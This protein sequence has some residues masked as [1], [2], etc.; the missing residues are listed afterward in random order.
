MHL[1]FDTPQIARIV[2]D[3]PTHRNAL[4]LAMWRMLI[5]CCTE[6]RAKD[7]VRVVILTG[8]D[9]A[10]SSGADITEFLRIR[11]E[12]GGTRDYD[13]AIESAMQAVRTLDVPVVADIRGVCV[14]GGVA[15]ALMCDMRIMADDAR[16]GIPAG[17]LGIAYAP[18]WIRRLTEVVGP[19]A[20]SELLFT[21]HIFSAA[22]AMQW[23]FANALA[24]LSEIS[25]RVGELAQR[26]AGLA[27]MSI[28]ASKAAI[29]E[30]SG[31]DVN[32][33]WDRAQRLARACDESADYRRGVG[34]F[35]AGTTAEFEG[36]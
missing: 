29:R 10:F 12:P 28:R 21:A 1:S 35:L 23:G 16:F 9:S 33:G 32:R 26:M 7:E 30:S 15:L 24:P 34:A 11:A 22:R 13:E 6:I 17:K 5:A 2:I 8:D 31:L 20:S 18:E 19:S 3:N 36:V 14:G 27:P 4:T 25:P